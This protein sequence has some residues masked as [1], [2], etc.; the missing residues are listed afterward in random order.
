VLEI[1]AAF[2]IW[3]GVAF[4]AAACWGAVVVL[5]KRVLDY[6]RPLLVNFLVLT[7]STASLVAIAVP[8]TVL[9]LWPLGFG[10]TWAAAGYI[11]VGAAVTWLIA[12]NAYYYALRS[13]RIGVVGPLCSTD[14]LF[15][16]VFA[17]TLVSA[18]I[19]GLTVAGLIVTIVGVVLISRFMGDETEP[20]S[21][22]LAGAAGPPTQ[23]SAA[24]IVTLSLVTA[25]GWGFAPVMIQ[26]AE[27][28]TGGATTT[29]MV[30]GEALGVVVLAPL[31]VARRASLF[32]GELGEARRRVVA[33]LAVAGFL[34]AA[35]AVLFYVLIE[36]IG[37]VLTTLIIATSPVFAILGGVLVLKE[38][39]G[40]RLALG[41][42]VTLL[43]VLLATLQRV[44]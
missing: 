36:H 16:A 24:S 7:V 30:L 2:L 44:L 20:H 28:S 13:G 1:S 40:A 8:L 26:L 37:P 6:V 4:L 11:A 15:T 42:G 29:M 3:V 35:F 43:G 32:A 27:R 39:V 21:P 25:A 9:R 23:A 19:G 10:M 33:L 14:P 17:A 41:A 12:F 31:V 18:V 5:N 38:R 34:N 22:V